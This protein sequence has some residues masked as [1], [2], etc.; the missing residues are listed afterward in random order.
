MSQKNIEKDWE[1][2][3]RGSEEIIGAG[4]LRKKLVG[5][6]K[7]RVKFGADPTAP[8]L[9]LGH[10]VVMEKLR[11]FQKQGHKILFLIGDFTALIGDPSG[12]TSE[13]P[14]LTKEE[15]EESVKGYEEQIF[16]VLGRDNIEIVRNSEWLE[17]L[18]A[19][20]IIRLATHYTV[21]RMLERNDFEKR[22]KE[23]NPISITEF[24]YPLLQGYDSVHLKSDIE[25]GGTDQK[26]NL[27]MGR[28][29]QKDW[30]QEPQAILTMPL[31]EG[32]D[33]VK[34]M[35]KSYGNHIGI[36]ED[37]EQIFGKIMSISD[38]MMYR[39]YEL[40]TMEDVGEIRAMHPME[41]KKKLG[42][43]IIKKYYSEQTAKYERKRFEDKFSKDKPM[44]TAVH[45]LKANMKLKDIIKWE[46][47]LHFDEK[48]SGNAIKTLIKSGSVKVDGEK[49]TDIS[50]ELKVGKGS[51][52][53]EYGKKKHTFT[54]KN[55]EK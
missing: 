13:R 24:L 14:V 2:I 37:P 23:G 50:C 48:L 29:L 7:L 18:G 34:K 45:Q 1:E 53:I 20:G 32:T 10:T 44:I 25:I 9:H 22:Y 28:D 41:A 36:D 19:E 42:E 35:S 27:L 12:R 8:D 47:S 51:V 16:K 21:A 55:V 38:D 5:G 11:V 17:P 4:E 54:V 3:A 33:G 26:F 46:G 40:L 49:I 30:G 39:Y 43:V 6:K 15:I 52:K 31:L